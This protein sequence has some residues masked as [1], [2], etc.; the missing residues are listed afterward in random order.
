MA[1]EF[2][3]ATYLM[4]MKHWFPGSKGYRNV[5]LKIQFY[6]V[7]NHKNSWNLTCAHFKSLKA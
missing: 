7:Q 4:G 2:T 5:K 1:P 3:D 6:L